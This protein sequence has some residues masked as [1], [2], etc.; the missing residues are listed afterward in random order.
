MSSY[1]SSFLIDPVYR[2]A[3][4][5]SRLSTASDSPQPSFSNTLQSEP[6]T[7]R[8]DLSPPPSI[9]EDAEDR[10]SHIASG[11]YSH[12]GVRARL[13]MPS[14]PPE[15]NA[16]EDDTGSEVPTEALEHPPDGLLSRVITTRRS[17]IRTDSDTSTNPSYS[18]PESLRSS[19]RTLMNTSAH[20][21]NVTSR[22]RDNAIQIDGVNGQGIQR[23]RSMDNNLITSGPIPED[24]GMAYLRKRIHEIREQ[25][26]PSEEKARLVHS[27]MTEQWNIS[28]VGLLNPLR[29][30]S[31]A[32][33]ASHERTYTPQSTSQN[34]EVDHRPTTPSSMS[35]A[36]DPQNPYNVT[37]ADRAPSYATRNIGLQ[38]TN[39]STN[40]GH[41]QNPELFEE[42]QE[43]ELGCCHY[44]R[45]VKL[46]CYTCKRWYTCRFCHDAA[47]D[48]ALNRKE[49][50]NM[51]C[52]YCG[53]AQPAGQWC[54][55]CGESAAWY[56]CS[57]CKLWDNDSEKSIY[58][59]N[60][61]GIC[62][63]GK[64][65]GKDFFHCK[66]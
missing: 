62:R 22:S 18:V 5:F 19:N 17:A 38:N 26:I 49:T 52:M 46:Q 7:A 33:F 8:R 28:Q 30:Y 51:L 64:G 48:H 6:S 12:V 35:S 55:E 14:P 56:Y 61:C 34:Q 40:D 54:K 25:E 41:S 21:A 10:R 57:I 31:P 4:R 43:V 20:D 27:L 15:T 59:C 60:D 39:F 42:E 44:K 32:S 63:V 45:N 66:V 9:E 58:H 37:A 1:I 50:R 16:P 24:D 23:T 53:C 11:S 36:M 65:I 3:R 29:P 47:E 13:P 2:H